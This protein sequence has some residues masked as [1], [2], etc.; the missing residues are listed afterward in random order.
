M[1]REKQKFR[2]DWN[3]ILKA[4]GKDME[5]FL[6]Q[7]KCLVK[8]CRKPDLSS[9]QLRDM[10]DL[11]KELKEMEKEDEIKKRIAKCIIK[12]EYAKKRNNIPKIFYE[13]LFYVL[14]NKF[15]KEDIEKEKINN[16]VDFMEAVVAY[17]KK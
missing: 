5:I 15:L 2:V 1:N 8:N 12:L 14:N 4:K 10:W 3:I 9:S 17:S 16:F 7:A 6:D 13:N 11:I